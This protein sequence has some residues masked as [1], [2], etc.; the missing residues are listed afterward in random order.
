MLG[1]VY[2]YFLVRLEPAMRHWAPLWPRLA[3]RL[4]LPRLKPARE[5]RPL[6]RAEH[7]GHAAGAITTAIS[8]LERIQDLQVAAARQLDA[9][10]YA[11]QHLL[12]E[13]KAAMPLPTDGASVQAVVA[14]AAET[15]AGAAPLAA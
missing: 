14:E 11:L 2:T 3:V 5:F 10:E 1:Q 4:S 9:A 6:A 13:L 15:P 12:E 7:W 8:G